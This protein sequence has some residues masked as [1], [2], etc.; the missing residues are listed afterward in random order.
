MINHS[1]G[2][3]CLISQH[4]QRTQSLL[5]P[6]VQRARVAFTPQMGAFVSS[7]APPPP[8]P[9]PL[10]MATDAARNAVL[11][12]T[13]E[14]L[15][16]IILL[17]HVLRE[18][19]SCWRREG[20]VGLYKHVVGGA[21]A[22][23][24]AVVPGVASTV[25]KE[26]DAVLA[27]LEKDL[28][29]DGDLHALL[30]IP[31]KGWSSDE[32]ERKAC[33]LL[34]AEVAKAN[35]KKWAGI[36]H[37][38][39]S[40]L[41]RLQGRVWSAFVDTNTLYPTVFPSLRKFEAEIVSMTLSIVHGHEV[42]ACGLLASGGSEAI[43][44]AALAYREFARVRGMNGKPQIIC[45]L[46]AHPALLKACHYFGI[47]LIKV[48]IEPETMQLRAAAVAQ[49][50]TPRTVAIYASAPSFS[51]GVVDPIEELGALAVSRNIGLHVDNCLGGYLLSYM[52][53]EGLYSAPFDF[54]VRGVTSM[55][56][57]VH[58]YGCANKGASVACFRDPALRRATYVPSAEGCEGL[59]V[60]PTLQGS[61]SGATIAAAWATIVHLGDDG[62]ARMARD[63]TACH[64]KIKANVRA[65]AP[66]RLCCDADATV[67][68]ICSDGINVY[69]LASLLE[70]RGWGVFTGQ[71]P[72]TLTIPVGEQT[73]AYVDDL[74]A[75]L[76]EC[77]AYL[78]AHPECKASGNAA[79][80]GAAAKMPSELLETILRGYVDIKMSVKPAQDAV[81]LAP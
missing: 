80:Y 45:S 9:P 27:G 48:A 17:Q 4:T 25:A 2:V 50:I 72:P 78:I 34:D 38:G 68:P 55:S 3:P 77:L 8:S 28:H 14:R 46:S 6:L 1:P 7:H 32:V 30:E 19:L 35:G 63:I 15:L 40:E 37:A 64:T 51:H 18:M 12:L 20:L 41:S 44:L 54:A 39:G 10:S 26:V 61:R 59:Y 5:S 33:A 16:L 31:R 79:V 49:H 29:G 69:A 42:G 23:A 13:F 22:F 67:V 58:K 47:E 71:K 52:Q 53:R 62:Y 56:V 24:S 11:A 74:L 81:H 70:E 57:D 75:D 76:R 60:T 43:L 65:M 21:F 36:Y 73:P 66:L